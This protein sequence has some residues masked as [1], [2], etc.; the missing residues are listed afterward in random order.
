MSCAP[1]GD[2]HDGG[3]ANAWTLQSML[4]PH[5]PRL[6]AY[7]R[8]LMPADVGAV[9]DPEDVVQDAMI[10][11]LCNDSGV[12][13]DSP[14]NVWRW[15]A[16]IARHRLIKRIQEQ[17]ALKRGGRLERIHQGED[18]H[19]NIIGMLS[20]LAVHQHTPSRS[21]AR[22]ELVL[23]LKSSLD[24]MPQNY[25]EAVR[26]RYIEGLS[27]KQAARRL[28]G[29]EESTRKLCVRGLDVLRQ[30]LRSATRFL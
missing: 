23:I 6:I 29:T 18:Q 11:G 26:L 9:I 3:P 10:E 27:F 5:A 17:R 24:R 7:V 14:D 25:R 1:L 21:V 13:F 12:S 22:R 8:S 4:F 20:D 28:G 15:I 30:D 2:K 16:L 19:G